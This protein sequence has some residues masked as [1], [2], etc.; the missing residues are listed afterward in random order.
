MST[1]ENLP[2]TV[3]PYE[4]SFQFGS[5]ILCLIVVL[6]GFFVQIV[7]ITAT[8]KGYNITTGTKFLLSVCFADLMFCA[9]QATFSIWNLSAGGW[10]VS[11]LD[12]VYITSGLQGKWTKRLHDGRLSYHRSRRNQSS[13]SC[14][15]HSGS[16]SYRHRPETNVTKNVSFH[17]DCDLDSISNNVL[18]CFLF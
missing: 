3:L 14:D 6:V 18:L 13:V 17:T 4:S 5:V 1:A 11:H 16:L 15:C 8:L 2:E 9:I 12:Y 10:L 7:V